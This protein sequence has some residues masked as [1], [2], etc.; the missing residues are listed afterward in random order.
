MIRKQDAM[1]TVGN[2]ICVDA[3]FLFALFVFL[4][5]GCGFKGPPSTP[6]W[7][8]PPAVNDLSYLIEGNSIKLSWSIPAAK[9]KLISPVDGFTVYRSQLSNSEAECEN[10]PLTFNAV[11]HVSA[12]IKRDSNI[13]PEPIT[14]YQILESGFSYVYMVRAYSDNG[15]VSKDS[16]TIEF[17]FK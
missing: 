4:I 7:A 1:C 10:C 13:K 14:F 5:F 9:G 11:G 15:M 12:T 3:R 2:Q 16:N 17:V 6:R 8:P